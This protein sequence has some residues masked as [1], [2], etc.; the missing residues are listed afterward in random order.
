MSTE[1]TLEGNW[2]IHNHFLNIAEKFTFGLMGVDAVSIEDG[3]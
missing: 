1:W 2:E 3:K